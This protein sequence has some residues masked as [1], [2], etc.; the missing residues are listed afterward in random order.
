[1]NIS[2][3]KERKLDDHSTIKT[4]PFFK[5]NECIVTQTNI[6][7]P[8]SRSVIAS[9]NRRMLCA[10]FNMTGFLI[11][12]TQKKKFKNTDKA[13]IAPNIARVPPA[14]G[15]LTASTVDDVFP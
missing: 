13:A 3:R 8:V 10:D 9:E 11:I 4:I 7:L 14:C 15:N 1:M 6:R 5:K 12:T 2:K